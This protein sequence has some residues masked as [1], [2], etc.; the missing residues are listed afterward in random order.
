MFF[1]AADIPGL[2]TLEAAESC[3]AIWHTSLD[4]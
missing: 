2:E 4:V 3:Q 1:S